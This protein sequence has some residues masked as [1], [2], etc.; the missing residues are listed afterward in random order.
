MARDKQHETKLL[1]TMMSRSSGGGALKTWIRSSGE[2][3]TESFKS[4]VIVTYDLAKTTRHYS[5]DGNTMLLGVT[6]ADRTH[7]T[8]SH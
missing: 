6:L 3:A 8:Q 7:S 2:D 1:L 5:D 4:L